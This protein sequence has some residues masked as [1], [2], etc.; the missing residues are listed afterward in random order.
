MGREQ[1]VY[2]DAARSCVSLNYTTRGLRL[3]VALQRR[4]AGPYSHIV[5]GTVFE[6]REFIKR[7][8]G[9]GGTVDVARESQTDEHDQGT[10][11]SGTIH[12]NLLSRFNP[13][14]R[15]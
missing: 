7:L 15:L 5:R 9:I 13:T 2:K 1:L 11:E 12:R 3:D 10:F 8:Q 14:E 6:R 4:T